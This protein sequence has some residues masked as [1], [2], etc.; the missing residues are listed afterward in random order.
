[1]GISVMSTAT[2]RRAPEKQPCRTCLALVETYCALCTVATCHSAQCSGRCAGL[3][4]CQQRLCRL[5]SLEM[6]VCLLC[7]AVLQ[8]R[9]LADKEDGAVR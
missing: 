7:L 8:E 1:M 3:L 6:K 4:N 5:C 9:V 2:S